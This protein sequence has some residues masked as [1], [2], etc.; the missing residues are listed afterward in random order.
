MYCI[1][2]S[3]E[4]EMASWDGRRRRRRRAGDL[5]AERVGRSPAMCHTHNHQPARSQHTRTT[6]LATFFFLP[7]LNSHHLPASALPSFN[8]LQKVRK[9]DLQSR[10]AGPFP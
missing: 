5:R 7:R 9:E 4:R 2:M 6:L 3:W 8:G 10:S 1:R